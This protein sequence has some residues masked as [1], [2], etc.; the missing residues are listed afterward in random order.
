MGCTTSN[1]SKTNH[2]KR[3]VGDKKKESS[4]SKIKKQN[5]NRDIDSDT[6]SDTEDE[7]YFVWL[8]TACKPNSRPTL[9]R[10]NALTLVSRTEHGIYSMLE[11]RMSEPLQS[12]RVACVKLPSKFRKYHLRLV[13]PRNLIYEVQ[14]ECKAAMRI[15]CK[16]L[17]DIYLGYVHILRTKITKHRMFLHIFGFKE[18]QRDLPLNDLIRICPSSIKGIP[19][20]KWTARMICSHYE[21]VKD[22]CDLVTLNEIPNSLRTLEVCESYT[23]NYNRLY[24]SNWY[25][26]IT[27]VPVPIRNNKFFRETFQKHFPEFD[28]TLFASDGL[29]YKYRPYKSN[30]ED[31][32]VEI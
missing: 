9:I 2:V 29:E 21:S 3:G 4:D 12:L 18:S 7:D 27:A 13:M 1:K 31:L 10:I 26:D 17:Y 28:L 16:S 22:R 8:I 23:R 6:D 32:W 19:Q 11:T 5:E 14:T 15:W 25:Y 24:I 20:H 30:D